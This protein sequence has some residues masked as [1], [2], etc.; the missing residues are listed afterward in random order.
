MYGLVLALGM[1]SMDRLVASATK[2]GWHRWLAYVV[3]TGAGFYVHFV[4]ILLIPAQLMAFFLLRPRLRRKS[5]WH[6]LVSLV[7]LAVPYLPILSWQL[8]ALLAPAQTGFQFVPLPEMLISIFSS[9]SLGVAGGRAPWALALFA[10]LLL[11]AVLGWR[12][13]GHGYRSLA[14]LA[15]WLVLP[16]LGFF[17][18]TLVLPLYTARYL[19]FILPAYLALLAGGMAQVGQR[20]PGLAA[21]AL[22]SV[23]VLNAGGLWRQATTPIKADYRAAT[24]YVMERRGFGEPILFQIPYGRYAFE[25]Y[26]GQ[27][28]RSALGQA[29]PITHYPAG[30]LMQYGAFA[31]LVMVDGRGIFPWV[32]GLYT[33]AGMDSEEADRR[34]GELLA[35]SRVMWLFATETSMWD[36]RG[37]VQRWLEETGTRIDERHFARVSVYRYELP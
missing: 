35:G 28:L 30:V 6:W 26:A 9:Y 17:V 24:R 25:Y 18:V 12:G 4:S 22:G 11:A 29:E 7:V 37:M 14:I 32:D 8:P 3:A 15:C 34:M 31:P 1:L 23:L 20:A 13:S 16:T 10:S 2:G 33:N 36:E 27:A 5:W 19:I 21:L